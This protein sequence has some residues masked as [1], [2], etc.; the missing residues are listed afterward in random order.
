M[1]LPRTKLTDTTARRPDPSGA[2]GRIEMGLATSSTS[3]P[4]RPPQAVCFPPADAGFAELVQQCL[5]RS[6]ESEPVAAAIQALLREHQP[7]AVVSPRH[8]LAA[9][10]GTQVW[11]VFRDGS[12]VPPAEGDPS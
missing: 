11:Y 1:P 3:T 12:I 7:L 4:T 8:A 10:D 6:P 5:H 9:L 2:D